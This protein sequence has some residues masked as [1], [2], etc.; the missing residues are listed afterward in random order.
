M[1]NVLVAL[2]SLGD[3]GCCR[4]T[5]GPFGARGP[6][7]GGFDR[8]YMTIPYRSVGGVFWGTRTAS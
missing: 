3:S 1:A 7:N 6:G 2:R 5:D 4:P 8:G